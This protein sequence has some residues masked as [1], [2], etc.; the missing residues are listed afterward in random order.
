MKKDFLRWLPFTLALSV[1]AVAQE[2]KSL[3]EEEAVAAALQN[4]KEVILANLE[5]EASAARYHQTNAVFLPQVNL[6][7]TAFTTNNPLNAFGF[8]LQQQAI[9][10]TDFDPRLLNNPSATQNFM[11][12]AEI[13]Q[14]LINLDM[15]HARQAA[16]H[17]VEVYA[18][19]SRRTKEYIRFEVQR[20]YGQLQ[21][22]HE[23]M[24]VLTDARE[25]VNAIHTSTQQRLEKGF[26]QKSDVLQVQVQVNA[27]DSKLAEAKS[28]VKNAS[29]YLA[30]L[31]GT[32]AGSIYQVDSIHQ[33]ADVEKK[34][35]E[36]P[37]NRADFKAMQSAL[38]AQ[39]QMVSSGKMAYLPKLNAFG[40]FQIND[41]SAFH[42]NSQS[43]LLGAQL[44]WNIFAGT[45]SRFKVSEYKADRSRMEQQLAYQKEQGQLELSKTVRQCYDA[46]FLITQSETAVQQAEE[47]LR[48]L[49]NRFQQGLVTTTDLL[50]AQSSLSQQKLARAQAIFQFNT[51]LS[52]YE[53]LTSTSEK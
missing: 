25:T 23:A 28:N 36:V 15:I 30:L 6:S 1:S 44:S 16:Q 8:K 4:N 22:A 48:I 17:Q 38:Q 9:T 19:K 34:E 11:A 7:Y 49:N 50:Q 32:K 26:L 3:K 42:F 29:D 37:E 33:R 21:L 46:A 18:Y 47:V 35:T 39:E 13:N 12:K 51:T 40:N 5:Q 10:Q 2:T 45:A 53:F 27:V 43:Y 24:K 14:P 31:M 41:A 52:Y 20:A